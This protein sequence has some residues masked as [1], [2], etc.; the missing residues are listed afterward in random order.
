M[1]VSRGRNDVIPRWNTYALDRHKAFISRQLGTSYLPR[2]VRNPDCLSIGEVALSL[3]LR[4]VL[5]GSSKRQGHC[6]DQNRFCSHA[7]L[8]LLD[9]FNPKLVEEWCQKM[10]S[11]IVGL[12]DV[13]FPPLQCRKTPFTPLP[14]I[15]KPSFVEDSDLPSALLTNQSVKKVLVGRLLENPP[16]TRDFNRRI[17]CV[18]LPGG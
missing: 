3:S 4:C 16:A 14:A 13:E 6:K 2:E 9:H 8:L 5:S 10:S 11:Y 1:R 18:V 17:K 15:P 7:L 12:R